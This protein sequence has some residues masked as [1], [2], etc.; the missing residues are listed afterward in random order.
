M[1][2]KQIRSAATEI[3]SYLV[4]YSPYTV[5]EF[6]MQEARQN[7]NVSKKQFGGFWIYHFQGKQENNQQNKTSISV[8]SFLS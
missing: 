1:D 4:E 8:F 7:E 6:V 3:L 5:Q 2:D